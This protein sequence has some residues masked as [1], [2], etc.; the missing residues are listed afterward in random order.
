MKNNIKWLKSNNPELED[1]F[2][3]ILNACVNAGFDIKLSNIRSLTNYYISISKDNT[4]T[5]YDLIFIKN[6]KSAL[7]KY[8]NKLSLQLLKSEAL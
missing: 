4:N 2:N 1:E 8:E 7:Q 6:M 5:N 3:E